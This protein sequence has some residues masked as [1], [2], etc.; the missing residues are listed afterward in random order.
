MPGMVM[1]GGMEVQPT[2]SKGRYDASANFGMAGTW[3]MAIDW[4]GP[5]GQGR[6]NF[7]ERVQ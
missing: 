6:A 2:A 7:D 5:A 3:Q 1:P 4:N